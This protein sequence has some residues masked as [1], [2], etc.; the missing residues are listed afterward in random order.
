M[1]KRST[2]LG[3]GLLLCLR[4]SAQTPSD[5]ILMDAGE[6]CVLFDYSFST[7]DTYWEGPEKRENQTIAAVNRSTYLPMV[8]VGVLPKLNAYVGLPYV[9]TTS[10]EPN[11]G[12]FAGAKGFQ[13]LFVGVKYQAFNTS[14]SSANH[15][16]KGLASVGFSTPA[17]NYLPDYMPYSLGLGAPEL[18]YRAILDYTFK[19]SWSLRGAASYLWRGYAKAEREFYYNDG[20]YYTPWMDVPN[21]ISVEAVLVKWL[22][23]NTLRAELSYSS[24]N[25]RSGDDIRPYAAPQPT[26]KIE[27]NRVGLMVNYQVKSLRGL[28]VIGYYHQIIDG[29]NAPEARTGGVGVTYLFQL[30]KKNKG[31][32]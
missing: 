20:A 19:E 23:N 3:L 14:F 5:A 28:G 29:R 17:S 24:L 21:A 15:R 25:S 11:G 16:L 30:P 32:N 13:D 9:T 6:I 26:N 2:W 10:T 22:M 31:E 27:M 7:F 18:S 1:K 12:Y 4:L 8:A